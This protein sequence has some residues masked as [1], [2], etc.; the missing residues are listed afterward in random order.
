MKRTPLPSPD[1][2][3]PVIKAYGDAVKRG[4]QIRAEGKKKKSER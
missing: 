4:R 3:N 1:P 2:K